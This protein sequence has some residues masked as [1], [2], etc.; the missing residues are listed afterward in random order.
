MNLKF[1]DYSLDGQMP[2][3]ATGIM[4]NLL[5]YIMYFN[6]FRNPL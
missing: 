4:K 2:F 3:H 5:I 6:I 1:C